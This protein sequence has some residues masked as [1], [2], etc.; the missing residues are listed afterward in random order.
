MQDAEQ[1]PS[2]ADEQTRRAH[3][4]VGQLVRGRWR[5][6]SL[7]GVG[8][9]AAVYAA[10]HRNGKR[11]ALKMLH[12]ELS[13]NTEVRQRFVDE[14]YAANR[15]GHTG[16]VSVI[17]DDVAEDGSAFLVMDL[18]EG[19]TLETRLNRRGKLWPGEVLPIIYALLDV[20]AAAHEKGIVHRDIKPDNVFVTSEGKVKLL[21]F[22][23]A[24]M[25]Q[26]GRPR[27]TQSGATMGTPAFMPPEQARGRWDQLDGRT[28]LWAVGATMFIQLTGRQVRQAE[29]PNEE[30]LLAMTTPAP[31]LR[32]YAPDLPPL[33]IELVDRA[34]A[35]E[36]DER[37][38][39]ARAMQAAVRTVQASLGPNGSLPIATEILSPGSASESAAPVTLLTPHPIVSSAFDF[40]P[41]WRRRK[42]VVVGAAVALA[43][44]SMAAVNLQLRRRS[45]EG[46][47]ALVSPAPAAPVAIDRAPTPDFDPPPIAPTNLEPLATPEPTSPPVGRELGA[48]VT[49]RPKSEKPR[50]SK[51]APPRAGLDSKPS[52]GEDRPLVRSSGSNAATNPA[53]VASPPESQLP[54]IVDPL[55]RRR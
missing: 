18:L 38:P 13:T 30:L 36:Q 9:M 54:S 2:I 12:T 35:F 8:G 27:T 46:S 53:T 34:L 39:N 32:E 3:L 19:E 55:D 31:S 28:D 40:R 48:P 37:W 20:L 15:V 10:T 43:F 21:D 14:G 7:L 51:S 25:I 47:T 16:A 24:R 50:P 11:V 4:R 6:D 52:A 41:S 26:P 49:R 33:L 29:T 5:L 17:D 42:P 44:L 45:D 23:I 1:L 22:G